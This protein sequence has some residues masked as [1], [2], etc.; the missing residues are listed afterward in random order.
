MTTNILNP[1]A[2]HKYKHQAL[3]DPFYYAVIA[4]KSRPGTIYNIRGNIPVFV[5]ENYMK[6]Q[7]HA[8]F[9]AFRA[10]YY[11]PLNHNGKWSIRKIQHHLP[12]SFFGQKLGLCVAGSGLGQSLTSFPYG[13]S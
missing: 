3:I 8:H 7:K 13:K 10:S 6:A 4:G 12:S 2:Y 11:S 5:L 9:H 1:L